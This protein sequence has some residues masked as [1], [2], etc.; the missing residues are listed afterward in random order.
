MSLVRHGNAVNC[1]CGR[2]GEPGGTKRLPSL[3]VGCPSTVQSGDRAMV[4]PVRAS[5]MP[6][7]AN[8][9]G[10]RLEG[11]AEPVLSALVDADSQSTA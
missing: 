7:L 9:Q 8:R 10:P 4:H 1:S 5:E 11:F 3:G 6:R 2:R